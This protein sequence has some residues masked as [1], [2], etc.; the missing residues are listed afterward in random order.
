M[1]GYSNT[2]MYRGPRSRHHQPSILGPL[3]LVTPATAGILPVSVPDAK[4]W[5]R[6]DADDNT[7]DTVIEGI[8]NAAWAYV[9]DETPGALEML[10]VTYDLPVRHW[11]WGKPLWMPRRPLQSVTSVK[12]LDTANVQQTFDASNYGVHIPAR[13]PGR[14]EIPRLTIPP[15]V[16]AFVEYP[17]TVRFVAGWTSP[18]NIPAGVKQAILFLVAHWWV[19]REAVGTVGEPTALALQSLLNQAGYGSYA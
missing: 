19:N 17:I 4:P 18:A 10:T 11:W 1:F 12:Y 8:I 6:V 3:E 9:Q 5:I 16:Y 7:Q 15:P 2:G 14:I 13:A